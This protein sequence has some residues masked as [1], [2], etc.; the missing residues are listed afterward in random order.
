MKN[1]DKESDE[2]NTGYKNGESII[3]TD[4]QNIE[5]YFKTLKVNA[6]LEQ[7]YNSIT[8]IQIE[9]LLKTSGIGI[10]GKDY[11]NL[12]GSCEGATL[13][14]TKKDLEEYLQKYTG[15]NINDFSTINLIHYSKEYDLYVYP[16]SG[17]SVPFDINVVSGYV[18]GDGNYVINYKINILQEENR[19][20]VLKKLGNDYQFISNTEK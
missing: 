9:E 18:N 20:V 16:S 19:E 17:P 14:V 10:D 8:D 15:K 1:Q 3:Q 4:L 7:K 6:F 13:K 12:I 5:D 2:I 11:C